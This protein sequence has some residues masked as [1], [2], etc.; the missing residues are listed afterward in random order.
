MVDMVRSRGESKLP[1]LTREPSRNCDILGHCRDSCLILVLA[2]MCQSDVQRTSQLDELLRSRPG[3]V[4]M[5]MTSRNV[6]LAIAVG[7][8]AASV[9]TA[10]PAV[11]VESGLVQG[12]RD[13]DLVIYRDIPY[14]AP[15]IDSLRWRS[16]RPPARWKG[17]RNATS[18]GLP[19][20]QPKFAPI[21][22]VKEWSEDCLTANVWTPASR[23]P[24]LPPPPMN[25]LLDPAQLARQGLVVVT[26][27]YRLRS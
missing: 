6:L 3:T 18:F 23:R 10:Q 1:P 4:R 5:F 25:P 21:Q 2:R 7:L 14:A 26:F 8:S 12:T 20:P 22:F 13:G 16:P 9:S 17:V 19:C 11:R 15:P 24:S 27:N